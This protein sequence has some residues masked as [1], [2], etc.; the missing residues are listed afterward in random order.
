MTERKSIERDEAKRFEVV[1]DQLKS[2]YDEFSKLSAKKPDGALNKFKLVHLNTV[3]RDANEVLTQDYVPF[4]GFTEFDQDDLPTN[5]DVAMMLSQYQAQMDRFRKEH[6][7][8][9]IGT[10]YWNYPE[11]EAI[12]EDLAEDEEE[13]EGE[14]GM[15]SE[16]D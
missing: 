6:S 1:L 10:W 14:D 16:S 7:T 15:D 8:W 5:S 12:E 3:V 2:F 13:H 9:R 11:N 4:Q